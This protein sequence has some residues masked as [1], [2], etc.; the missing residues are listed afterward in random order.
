[1]L[2]S[3]YPGVVILNCLPACCRQR[4]IIK[5]RLE[6]IKHRAHAPSGT[7][8]TSESILSGMTDGDQ[9]IEVVDVTK[10]L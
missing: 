8:R 4:Q 5:L 3:F 9:R 6:M 10:Q 1:M 7:K 2:F